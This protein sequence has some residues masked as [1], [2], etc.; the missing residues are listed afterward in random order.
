MFFVGFK[1]NNHKSLFRSYQISIISSIF[2]QSDLLPK[3]IYLFEK[4]DTIGNKEPINFM[5]CV[6]LLRPTKEN[7]NLLCNELRNPKF[8]QYYLC[9]TN[10]V[11]RDEIKKLA[12]SD[13]NEVIKSIKEYYMDFCAINPHFFSLNMKKSCYLGSSNIWEYSAFDRTL[14]GLVSYLKAVKKNPTIR[15]QSSSEMCE[16]LAKGVKKVLN[17]D[18]LFLSNQVNNFIKKTVPPVLLIIDR[19]SDGFTPML[20][21]V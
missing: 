7:I 12:E 5:K 11:T 9:F 6:S 1:N 19:K 16:R 10:M 13:K 14:N 20:N 15:Y 17:E 4:I 21:Q 18:E 8:G 2:S 3:E